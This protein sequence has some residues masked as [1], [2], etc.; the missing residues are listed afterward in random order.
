M[1]GST[2]TY[3]SNVSNIPETIAKTM[4]ARIPGASS[5]TG[6]PVAKRFAMEDRCVTIA[7]IYNEDDELAAEGIR[8]A[9]GQSASFHVNAS[10]PD[11][12]RN[13]ID[14][15][16]Q[17]FGNP[18]SRGNHAGIGG[19]S[20]PVS[21]H[22]LEE[23]NDVLAANLGTVF[24]SM[25][26]GVPAL[27]K[28]GQGDI[29]SMAAILSHIGF[30]GAKVHVSV[31]HGVVGLTKAAMVDHA[32]DRFWMNAIGLTL[33]ITP[34]TD[35]HD[36]K[37]NKQATIERM[38]L[39]PIG[40]PGRQYE[41]AKLAVFFCPSKAAYITGSYFPVD[42]WQGPAKATNFLETPAGGLDWHH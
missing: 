2:R 3:P 13:L 21:D 34:R 9:G 27:R 33:I 5:E 40:R 10:S 15:A 4:Q 16:V 20:S 30:A 41:V 17:H 37:E 14:V 28:N 26:Y 11:D 42:G 23:W 35:N 7:D 24:Y 36:L 19:D 6:R 8:Q 25:K 39:S 22:A 1:A 12:S 29:M 38:G 31:E 32:E 18:D